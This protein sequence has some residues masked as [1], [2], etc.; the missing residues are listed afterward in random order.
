MYYAKCVTHFVYLSYGSNFKSFA[1]F[2]LTVKGP[3]VSYKVVKP[4]LWKASIDPYSGYSEYVKDDEVV[5]Y[6]SVIEIYKNKPND[7]ERGGVVIE[8]KN[9]EK[10]GKPL[11]D[12]FQKYIQDN[13]VKFGKIE[14]EETRVKSS[15][16]ESVSNLVH[17]TDP[18]SDFNQYIVFIDPGNK[19]KYDIIISMLISHGRKA[20]EEEMAIF[21]KIVNSFRMLRV[22]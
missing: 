21:K 15:K 16:Y 3:V 14:K 19:F 8:V 5:H 13:E 18:A 10:Y 22:K 20:T 12:V 1:G 9:I 6:Q 4:E 11:T 17:A 7:F 2:C